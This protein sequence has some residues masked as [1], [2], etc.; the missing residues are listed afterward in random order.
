MR[1]ERSKTLGTS[2]GMRESDEKRSRES[3]NQND[4]VAVS[5]GDTWQLTW[6]PPPF[7]WRVRAR[8]GQ[9]WDFEKSSELLSLPGIQWYAQK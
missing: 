7:R 3:K 1:P 2:I 6:Q 8:E 9:D 5:G 4:D